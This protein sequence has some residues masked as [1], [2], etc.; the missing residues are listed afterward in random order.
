[1]KIGIFDHLD[2]ADVPLAQFYENRLRLVEAYDSREFFAYHVAEHHCTPLGMSPSPSVYLSAVAQRTRRIRFGSLV[3]ILPLYHPLRLAGE[4]CMLDHMSNGRLQV[5]VGRGIS[6]IEMGFMGVDVPQSQAIYME[7]YQVLLK[8]LTQDKV[9]HEG[10]FFNFRNVPVVLKPLQ[11]P[12][13]PL[14]YGVGQIEGVDWCVNNRVNAVVN[15]SFERV[16]QITDRFRELWAK[17]PRA[18]GENSLLM[19]S[20]RHVVVADTDAKA[21]A[22]AARAYARWHHRFMLLWRENGMSPQFAQ[23][24]EDFKVAL[25][26]GI[27]VAG[28]AATV[29]DTLMDHVKRTGVNYLLTRFA[30]GDLSLAESLES[31]ERFCA[32]VMPTLSAYDAG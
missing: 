25:Q 17:A 30:Y 32:G 19:G 28:S 3:Y 7:S 8:A 24:P 12:H 31:V 2:G 29:R 18:P 20:G 9:N 13:P 22:I 23:M 26:M 6:P 10:R 15:G 1:M 27:A 4:I 11:Q 21:E 14:W 16:R 5:G